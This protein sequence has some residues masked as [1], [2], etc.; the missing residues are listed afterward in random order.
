MKVLIC[1]FDEQKFFFFKKDETLINRYL[2]D[3]VI[4]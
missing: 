2:I 1:D 3:A 4:E